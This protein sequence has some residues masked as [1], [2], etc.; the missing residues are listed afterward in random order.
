MTQAG[1]GFGLR[2]L[3]DE[4]MALCFSYCSSR[5]KTGAK[6][7]QLSPERPA[8]VVQAVQEQ[9]SLTKAKLM[10]GQPPRASSVRANSVDCMDLLT[11]F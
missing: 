11:A 9:A 7:V 2:F 10:G 5:K 3:G 1:S 8:Q 4:A 6:T